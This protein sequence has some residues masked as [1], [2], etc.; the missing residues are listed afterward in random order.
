MNRLVNWMM[1]ASIILAI[2]AWLQRDA[3]PLPG[4]LVPELRE[5]PRQTAV[6]RPMFQTTVGGVTYSVSPLYEYDITGLV[7]SMHD[8][9]AW[10]DWIHDAWKDRLN[11][12]D[13]CVVYG[14]NA[15]TG[16]YEGLS[17]S[18]GEFQCFFSTASDE[19][20]KAFSVS[21][22]SNNHLLTD[23]P[24]LARA[25]RKVHVGDQVRVHGYLAEYSHNQGFAFFRGTSTTRL[26][27]GNG[28]CETIY[29]EDFK[30]LRHGGGWWRAL[31]W[32]GI[33]G[34]LLCL[35]AWIALPPRFED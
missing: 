14:D 2:V 4:E 12:V 29:V 11:V 10:W 7:V 5:D 24:D 35:L 6:K 9:A 34:F 17:Y 27:T 8:S 25:L 19:K 20:W 15:R 1:L 21:D 16:A 31:F 33:G 28:A 13:L 22:L 18:S 30:L 26:D 3:L 23:R 32:V